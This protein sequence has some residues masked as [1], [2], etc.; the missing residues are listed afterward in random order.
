MAGLGTITPNYSNAVLAVGQNYTMTATP[1]T[2][3][4]FTN[5]TGG[6]ELPLEW[7]TNGTDGS[8]LHAIQPDFAGQLH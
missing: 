8:V 1:G 2:G 6:S 5:W 7:L 4:T 3:F